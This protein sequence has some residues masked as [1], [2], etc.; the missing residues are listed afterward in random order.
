[1]GGTELQLGWI[2]GVGMVGSLFV[3]LFVGMRIDQHGT[4]VVWLFSLAVF[5]LSCFAHLALATC[6]GPAIYVLRVIFCSSI[7]GIMGSSMTFIS[8]RVPQVRMAEMLGMLGTSGFLGILLGT[9]LGDFLLGTETIERWQ[10][11]RM[12]LVA[13]ML[14]CCS[15]PFAWLTTRGQLRPA[16]RR[17]PSLIRLLRS[18]HPGTV[19]LM[20]VA[21]GVALGLPATFLRTYAAELGILR[22]GLFFSVYALTAIATRVITRRLPERLGLEPVII[23]GMLGLAGTQLLFLLVDT[24]WQLIIP[25]LGYGICHAVMFP[26]VIAAGSRAFPDQHRGLGTT[27]VLAMS[28][29]GYVIGAPTVGVILHYS[30]LLGLPSYPTMFVVMSGLLATAGG[31]YAL[32]CRKKVLQRGMLRGPHRLETLVSETASQHP[33]AEVALPARPAFDGDETLTGA[34]GCAGDGDPGP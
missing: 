19:L 11:E 2:V 13:G 34:C 31:F 30:G 23:M 20:G 32:T 5:I 14:G 1:L 28:D 18:Y 26:S 22:I 17:Y 4:R 24:E 25:G 33:L 3:R 8:G 16:R 29:L 10:V 12:F 15:L 27:L 21:S 6:H 9:Q 7:A